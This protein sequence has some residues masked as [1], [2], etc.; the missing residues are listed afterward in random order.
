MPTRRSLLSPV[1]SDAARTVPQRDT[2]FDDPKAR[3]Q[4][5]LFGMWLFLATLAVLFV[6]AILGYVVVRVDNG[7]GFI[8]ANAPAPPSILLA[9]TVLLVVSSATMQ[10]AANAGRRGDPAQ[11]GMMLVTIAL[12]LGFL[13]IQAVAWRQWVTQGVLVAD[14]LYAWT[15]YVLTG[16]HAAHV[17]GGLPAMAITAVKAARAAY[18]PDNHRGIVYCAMYWPFLDGA[19]I[20]LYATLWFGSLR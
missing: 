7:D 14:N 2:P 5:G 1:R 16:M 3:F 10:R 9:S 17:L 12:A 20:V 8:P 11:G 13:A 6:S 15:F 19:W 4:A 18:T